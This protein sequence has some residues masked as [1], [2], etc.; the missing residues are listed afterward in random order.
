M[1]LTEVSNEIVK[2]LP[3]AVEPLELLSQYVLWREDGI[4]HKETLDAIHAYN[5][6]S[7][8]TDSNKANRLIKGVESP[9]NPKFS[10]EMRKTSFDYETSQNRNL[11]SYEAPE[12]PSFAVRNEIMRSLVKKELNSKLDIIRKRGIHK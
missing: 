7:S 2:H 4:S 6:R 10:A 5:Y 12:R 8:S 11:A 1:D 9:E 3:D